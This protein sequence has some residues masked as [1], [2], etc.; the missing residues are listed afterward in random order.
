METKKKIAFA[1]LIV[2]V[3]AAKIIGNSIILLSITKCQGKKVRKKTSYKQ[4][5][6]CFSEQLHTSKSEIAERIN[7]CNRWPSN[8]PQTKV[9]VIVM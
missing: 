8:T 9:I 4:R 3:I 2:I 1:I 5:L 7:N 6:T